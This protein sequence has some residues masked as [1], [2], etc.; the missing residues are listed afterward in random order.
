MYRHI[1]LYDRDTWMCLYLR[2]NFQIIIVSIFFQENRSGT[3]EL[4]GNGDAAIFADAT[5][6]SPND[7]ALLVLMLL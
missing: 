2:M 4:G 1:I 7:V 3:D 5:D 6:A